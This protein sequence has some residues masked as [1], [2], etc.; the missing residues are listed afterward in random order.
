MNY[1]ICKTSETI[2]IIINNNNN[3][4]VF[5]LGSTINRYNIVCAVLLESL[6]LFQLKHVFKI[7]QLLL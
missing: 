6:A 5:F 4:L 2:I 1:K 7:T 3:T